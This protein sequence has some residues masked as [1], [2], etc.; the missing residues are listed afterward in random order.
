MQAAPEPEE[1]PFEKPLDVFNAIFNETDS[2]D[3]NDSEE[4]GDEEQPAV[5]PG[6]KE[7]QNVEP[8]SDAGAAD[9]QHASRLGAEGAGTSHRDAAAQL[10]EAQKATVKSM[11]AA[12]DRGDPTMPST[13]NG[14]GTQWRQEPT[15]EAAYAFPTKHSDDEEE[16]HGRRD[17]KRSKRDKSKDKDSDRRKKRHKYEDRQERRD[18]SDRD[19]LHNATA[20]LSGEVLAQNVSTAEIMAV[21]A[22]LK[23]QTKKDKDKGKKRKHHSS[24]HHSSSKHH[25][26]KRERSP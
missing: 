1:L 18:R 19:L 22:Q 15:E 23:K 4:G 7:T 11:M 8:K 20:L 17:R 6:K 9:T 14:N 5:D 21:A 2:E 13:S 12:L 25:T 3:D 16:R 10:Q 26:S 24:K